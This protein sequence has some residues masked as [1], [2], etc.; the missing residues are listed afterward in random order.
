MGNI[1]SRDAIVCEQK[2]LTGEFSWAM[3]PMARPNEP[4]MLSKRTT[5]VRLGIYLTQTQPKNL[6]L[7]E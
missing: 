7:R 6:A 5:K 3:V 4:D 2:Y 1:Q